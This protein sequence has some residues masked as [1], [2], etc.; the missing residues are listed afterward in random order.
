[1]DS[2]PHTQGSGVEAE[3]DGVRVRPLDPLGDIR[4]SLCEIH[5]D[6]WGLAPRPVQWDFIV[7]EPRTM[8]GVH[9]HR[10]RWDVL[11]VLEGHATIGLKDIRRGVTSFGHVMA[12]DIPDE[13]PTVVTIPP[14]VAHG[15]FASSALRYLYGLTVAWD[16]TDEGLGCRY[17]DPGLGIRWPAAPLHILPRDL[18]LSDYAT[19]V[20]Q[21]EAMIVGEAAPTPSS[22]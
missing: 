1:M 12:I 21:Y 18:G 9:V 19:L 4:G 3:I 6:S 20:R 14:G 13:V 7:S 8:R 10:Q 22:P 5:R 16:G 11:V 15:V 2:L 17:D